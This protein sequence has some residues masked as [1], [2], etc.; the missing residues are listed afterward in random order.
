MTRAAAFRGA[1]CTETE[2]PKHS[3][4]FFGF[5]VR[6]RCIRTFGTV[7]AGIV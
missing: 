4:G 6:E 2:T 7:Y 3:S 5:R 1:A